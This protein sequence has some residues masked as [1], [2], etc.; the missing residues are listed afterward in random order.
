MLARRAAAANGNLAKVQSLL[1][2]HPDL[3][4]SPNNIDATALHWASAY[5]HE[6]VARFLLANKANVSASTK[7][8]DTPLHWAAWN[9]HKDVAK[10]LLANKADVNARDKYGNT[11]LRSAV[12]NDHKD[13]AEL[14]LANGAD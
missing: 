8:G 5:G 11:P 2:D 10:L 4:F 1:K 14:L 13:V 12:V 9:G 6:D 3:V 7:D